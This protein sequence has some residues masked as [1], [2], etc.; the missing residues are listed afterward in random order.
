LLSAVSAAC[1]AAFAPVSYAELAVSLVIVMNVFRTATTVSL[2]AGP[3]FV[4]PS[5]KKCASRWN[6]LHFA[7]ASAANSAWALEKIS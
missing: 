1:L 5:M 2:P 3:F 7:S 6:H 4:S